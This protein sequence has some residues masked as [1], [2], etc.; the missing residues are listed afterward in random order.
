MQLENATMYTLTI[1]DLNGNDV[2]EVTDLGMNLLYQ[3]D[4]LTVGQQVRDWK[5]FIVQPLVG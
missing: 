1:K 5:L 4:F 2:S 3:Y